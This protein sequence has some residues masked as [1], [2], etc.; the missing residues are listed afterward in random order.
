[1]AHAREMPDQRASAG[2]TRRVPPRAGPAACEP[3]GPVGG[4]VGGR[5][6]LV[7]GLQRTAGNRAVAA[8]V[9]GAPPVV[10][11]QPAACGTASP[12]TC[13][14]Y[15]SWVAQLGGLP[16][17]EAQDA[18]RNSTQAPST[19]VGD[20]AGRSESAP[21]AVLGPAAATD[22]TAV[23]TVGQGLAG[24]VGDHFI[25][26][27]TD[28]WVRQHLP[29]QL[30]ATAY[31]LPTD[32]ADIAVVLRHVWLSAH[33]RTESYSG[34]TLGDRSGGSA[35]QRIRKVIGEVYSG[36]VDR[37]VSPY[38][39]AAGRP[40]RS[41]VALRGLLHPGDVLVWA[42]HDRLGGRRTGGH[43]QTITGIRSDG[44][45]LAM[46]GNQPIGPEQA[47]Q[48]RVEAGA[49]SP[50]EA[51]LRSA[52][53]RRIEL[54]ALTASSRRDLDE[55]RRGGPAVPAWT[56][57]DGS[58]TLVAAGPPRSAPAARAVAGVRT[59]GLTDW[60][61]RIRAATAA[62]LPGIVEQALAELRASA[63]SGS[64]PSAAA[65]TD[66]GTAVGT[67]VWT[68][69]HRAG[70]LAEASHFR[71]LEGL[72]AT[73]DGVA[74]GVR[75]SGQGPVFAAL[76]TALDR[77]GRGIT[78]I[79]FDRRG[80]SERRLRRILLTGFDPFNTAD[81]TR[82]A[83]PGEWN[84]SGAAVLALDG[85]TV[86]SPAGP[87][88]VESVVLPV[89]FPAFDAGL[90]ESVVRPLAGTVDAVITV[91]QDPSLAAGTPVRLERFVVGVR[92]D[93]AGRLQHI[94][95]GGEVLVETP[96]PLDRIA[97]RLG[98]P[99]PTVGVPVTLGF[100]TEAAGRRVL[101]VLGSAA[102][103]VPARPGPDNGAS[104]VTAEVAE[105]TA[106]QRLGANSGPGG[107]PRLTVDAGG[108]VDVVV[109]E[110]PGGNFLSNEVSFRTLRA[111][112]AE[113]S[114]APSFHVHTQRGTAEAG[115]VIPA[116][117]GP[118]RARA[119]RLAG[120]VRTDLVRTLR[121]LVAATA[122]ELPRR[123]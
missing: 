81:V 29:P 66:L 44:T 3:A 70:D 121:A 67:A 113:H 38:L 6:A 22:A 61:D 90:V 32:C 39:D 65:A 25:D 16:A 33:H 118:G 56:W 83:R 87:V 116:E 43:T 47:G 99:A 74:A 101:A 40:L 23:S 14:T 104:R 12:Q 54:D 37:I 27:P 68:G 9:G 8:A 73:V 11:R 117:D 45:I 97:R 4:R 107:G 19:P 108:P 89:S 72:E 34:W 48:I 75:V 62:T 110:G 26:H 30:R 20:L 58:T 31:Q 120:Q 82:P 86:S 92:A 7:L 112:A 51:R 49:G 76:R 94:P 106:L 95:G 64:A 102:G 69:A 2:P 80:V 21:P 35:Q 122:A 15:G 77:A 41:Y 36:N 59:T 13:P 55:P 1:M 52:Q 18:A 5:A 42:H 63:E 115:G 60:T 28:A 111:L 10:Q 79:R 105:P 57:S 119:L 78:S 96:A 88:A 84:P 17:F 24:D 71:L 100:P 114:A 93:L 53:A 109:I 46:Q 91:S 85:T 98:R 103:L 50:T 123:P